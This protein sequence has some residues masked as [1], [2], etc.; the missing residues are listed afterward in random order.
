[1]FSKLWHK[2][3]HRGHFGGRPIITTFRSDFL[4]AFELAQDVAQGVRLDQPAGEREWPYDSTSQ[5]PRRCTGLPWHLGRRR[6]RCHSE[7]R[8]PSSTSASS[9]LMI[10]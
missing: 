5:P 8:L 3:L 4:E 7:Y 10:S 6:P 1:M 2:F 9:A